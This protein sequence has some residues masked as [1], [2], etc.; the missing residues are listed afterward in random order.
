MHKTVLELHP[1][2]TQPWGKRIR[3]RTPVLNPGEGARHWQQ[4]PTLRATGTLGATAPH[5]PRVTPFLELPLPGK[6]LL[7]NPACSPVGEVG[8]RAQVAMHH[9]QY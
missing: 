2:P 1:L 4:H 8:P 9:E 7:W 3:A 5:H 6:G